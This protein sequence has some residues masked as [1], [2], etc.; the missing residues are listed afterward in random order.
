MTVRSLKAVRSQLVQ[1]CRQKMF[2]KFY[3]PFECGSLEGYILEVGPEFFLLVFVEERMRFNGFCCIRT[4]DVRRLQAPAK[5][6]AF[7]EAAL[8]KR[9]E[10]LSEKP[11]IDLSDVSN[12]LRTANAAFPLVTIHR[13][14]IDPDVCHIG[15][16]AK[17]NNSTVFLLENW[18][19]CRLGHGS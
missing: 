11:D 18:S 1:A 13:E 16:V 6:A 3:T 2:A 9:G 14:R 10:Y 7:A 15:R 4:A 5:Y 17:I 19:G 12:L 8:R